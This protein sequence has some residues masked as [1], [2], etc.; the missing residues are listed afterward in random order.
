MRMMAKKKEDRPMQMKDLAKE[1][2]N[3]NIFKVGKRPTAQSK[4][5]EGQGQ[6]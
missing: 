1:I 4:V 3:T 2:R 6:S 5:I